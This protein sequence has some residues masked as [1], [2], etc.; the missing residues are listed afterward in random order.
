MAQETVTVTIETDDEND[1]LTVPTELVEVLGEEGDGAANVV[2]DL[3]ML[4]LAQQSHGI[5]HHS[6]EDVSENLED[7]EEL[8]MALFEERFGQSYAE[9]TGHG[10]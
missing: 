4:G 7:A 2:A 10:H 8:T 1:K 6:P 3:A 9:M 5:V